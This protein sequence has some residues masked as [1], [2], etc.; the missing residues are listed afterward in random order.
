M[1]SLIFVSFTILNKKNGLL[2]NKLAEVP[3]RN[4]TAVFQWSTIL[5]FFFLLL[6]WEIFPSQQ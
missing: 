1:L 4:P 6:K 3:R 5:F 2:L